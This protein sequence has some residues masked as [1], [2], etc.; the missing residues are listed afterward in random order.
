MTEFGA[1]PA[2]MEVRLPFAMIELEDDG[3]L[4]GIFRGEPIR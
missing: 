4:D 3:D 2:T 1:G